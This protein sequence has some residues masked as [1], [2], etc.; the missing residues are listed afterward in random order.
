MVKVS[1]RGA[2]SHL[3]HEPLATAVGRLKVC[4]PSTE[5]K[6]HKLPHNVNED[7]ENAN[8]ITRV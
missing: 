2:L 8:L 3:A 5:Q 4:V 6:W 7:L 1:I